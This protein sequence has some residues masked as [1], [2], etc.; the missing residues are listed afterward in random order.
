MKPVFHPH[1]VNDPFGDPAL[2]IDFLFEKRAMMFD[3]GDIPGLEPRKILR[4]SHIFTS[5]THMDHFTGFDRILRICIGRGK[6]LH[7]FGPE[8]FIDQ[9]GHKLAGY[10]WNL[11]QNYE[12]DFTII[13]NEYHEDGKI[14]RA[15]F[16][17]R[18]A[19]K[20]DDEEITHTDTGILLEENNFR[21]RA[22]HLDHKIP[23]LAFA[24]EEKKHINVWKN[25]LD[26]MGL[27]TGA[28]LRELKTAVLSEKPDDL[29]FRV[30]WKEDNNLKETYFPLGELKNSILE[31]T[32]GQKIA[33]IVDAI[34]H[35]QN[36]K[37]IVGLAHDA[38]MLFIEACFMKDEAQRAAKRYH[39]TSHQAGTLGNMARAKR[40][41]PFHFSARHL[42]HETILRQE[43][44]DAFSAK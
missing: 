27:P 21:V 40:L 17:C 1:L 34:Y 38:D 8:N 44:F 26:E 5:H 14:L 36:I 29:Q 19:F 32:S 24:L 33:Y 37:R 25:R 39:L 13:A 18:Q 16:H 23:C 22:V 43:V 31:I 9:V 12:T 11:V 15:Q 6:C 42:H 41:I 2:Y 7:I 10:T 28:W 3:L 20:K 4:L 35:E 30:W